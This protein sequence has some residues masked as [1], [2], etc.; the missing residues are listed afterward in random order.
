MSV[1]TQSDVDISEFLELAARFGEK[2]LDSSEKVN[3]ESQTFDRNLFKKAGEMGLTGLI[4]S[5]ENGGSA[6]GYESYALILEEIACYSSSFAVT[7]AVNGLPQIM[8][9]RHGTPDQK[10]RW[11]PALAS[12]E[13][14]GAFAL[15]EAHCGSDAAAL[16]T[17]AKKIDGKYIL[18][19]SKQFITHAGFADCYL[20]M[21]RTGGEGA[22]GIS[23][24][25]VEG[26]A[27]GLSAGRK[28]DKM[29][30]RTS[31]TG[32]IIL[33]NTSVDLDHLVGKEGQGFSVAMEA[34]DSGRITIA[35]TAVGIARRALDESLKYANQRKAFG[36]S[37]ADFQ[38]LQWMVADMDTAISASRLLVLDAARRKDAGKPYS[39]QA[40]QAKMFATDT[41][42]KVT[43]DA[44]QI[45]G[46]YGYMKEYPVERLMRDAKATQIVEGTNQIQK[47]IIAKMLGRIKEKTGLR[48]ESL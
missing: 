25:Y 1:S 22:S 20:V 46:G 40:S 8:L 14:L 13:H 37:I 17:K 38:G 34:L 41:A 11:L 42:M 27:Q 6:L 26:N 24:F 10:K 21:A 12:A 47:N 35:A 48:Y 31:P 28:E 30:W 29:G 36:K 33:E 32:S 15:T 23:C 4:A 19:G 7:I 5:E 9:E 44:V 2:E 3:D 39:R 18:N 43:T 16:T 45:F